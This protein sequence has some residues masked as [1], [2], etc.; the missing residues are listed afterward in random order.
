MVWFRNMSTWNKLSLFCILITFIGFGINFLL[1]IPSLEKNGDITSSTK[2]NNPQS[3]LDLSNSLQKDTHSGEEKPKKPEFVGSPKKNTTTISSEEQN[4]KPKVPSSKYY[5]NWKPVD[6]PQDAEMIKDGTWGLCPNS[7]HVYGNIYCISVDLSHDT[8]HFVKEEDILKRKNRKQQCWCQNDI[9]IVTMYG[10][11]HEAYRRVT[12]PNKKAYAKAQ[13]YAY[14][15]ETIMS[16]DFSKLSKHY[17][18]MLAVLHH[19]HQHKAVLWMDADSAF[20]NFDVRIEH[21]LEQYPQADLIMGEE[22]LKRSFPKN[23]NSGVILFRNTHFSHWFADYVYNYKGPRRGKAKGTGWHDQATIVQIL[24]FHREL[25]PRFGFVPH[26]VS[27]PLQSFEYNTRKLRSN[28]KKGHFI[29]HTPGCWNF[30]KDFETCA[31]LFRQ[32]LN[33]AMN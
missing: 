3:D 9:I 5:D 27:I 24:D 22:P 25:A 10:K 29:L 1:V 11:K 13:G 15:D 18:K 19:L 31:S 17:S 33:K 7:D 30:K 20:I 12:E 16:D 26:D 14:S 6:M 28:W 32:H 21:F 2:R 4:Q 23:L 8:E